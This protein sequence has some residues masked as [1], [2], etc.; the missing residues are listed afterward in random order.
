MKEKRTLF[1]IN[2]NIHNREFIYTGIEF[3]EFMCYLKQPIKNI[4]LLKADYSGNNYANNFKLVEGEENIKLLLKEDVYNYGDFGF[5]DYSHL[6]NVNNLSDSQVAELLFMAHKYK[7]LN[8]AFF[9]TL[10][11][12]FAYLAHDDGWFCKLYC[13]EN[14]D[15]LDV[16]N[17]KII[18]LIQDISKEKVNNLDVDVQQALLTLAEKGLLIDFS[19]TESN[20]NEIC[21]NVYIVGKYEDMDKILNECQKLKKDSSEQKCLKYKDDKWCLT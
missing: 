8:N 1:Y 18:S 11:N 3:C 2:A 6:D 4:L 7:S 12:R 21:V 19:E 14:D 9:E 15:F 10:G 17:G 5:V 13:R 16:L 20:N